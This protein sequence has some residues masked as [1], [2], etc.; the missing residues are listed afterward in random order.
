MG[1]KSTGNEK[2]NS[3][4]TKSQI[5]ISNLFKQC[6]WCEMKDLSNLKANSCTKVEVWVDS[7]L[8]F[9]QWFLDLETKFS[10]I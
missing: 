1:L 6:R 9:D 10:C 4:E 7:L 5:N 3:V 8:Q 2:K